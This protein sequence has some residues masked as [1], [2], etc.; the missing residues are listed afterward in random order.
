MPHTC[1]DDRRSATDQQLHQNVIVVPAPHPKTTPVPIVGGPAFGDVDQEQ[2]LV[3][4]ELT[5]EQVI[6][7]RAR[8]A[9][10]PG[11][12]STTSTSTARS[13]P[14]AC[15]S[16]GW[17]DQVQR[18]SGLGKHVAVVGVDSDSGRLAVCPESSA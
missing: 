5:G 13:R 2:P 10:G 1:E 16:G 11:W 18:L 14:G 9:H 4:E 7:R 8:A 3:S 12:C 15:S 17:V 6:D